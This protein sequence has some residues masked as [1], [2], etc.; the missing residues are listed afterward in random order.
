MHLLLV[1]VWLSPA[2]SRPNR[3][4][5]AEVAPSALPGRFKMMARRLRLRPMYEEPARFPWRYNSVLDDVVGVA[6]FGR[7]VSLDAGTAAHRCVTLAG[8]A[9]AYGASHLVFPPDARRWC[10]LEQKFVARQRSR[11]D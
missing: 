6:A 9:P 1:R 4:V 2:I 10:I 7:V 3:A 5:M 11:E 8:C